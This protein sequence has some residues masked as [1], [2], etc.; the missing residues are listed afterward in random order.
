MG[1]VDAAEV[2]TSVD[3]VEGIDAIDVVVSLMLAGTAD[4]LAV[5]AT[6]R[7]NE[8]KVNISPM[9]FKNMGECKCAHCRTNV[10]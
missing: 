10:G 6:E 7:C 1:M 9:C 5:A 8:S 2:P 3:W 4:G